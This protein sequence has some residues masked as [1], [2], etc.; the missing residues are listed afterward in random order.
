MYGDGRALLESAVWKCKRSFPH[1]KRIIF[2]RSLNPSLFFP[3]TQLL[4][5]ST[6]PRTKE[7]GRELGIIKSNF[8]RDIADLKRAVSGDVAKRHRHHVNSHTS[9]QLSSESIKSP[10]KWNEKMAEISSDD[11]FIMIIDDGR[12]S[13]DEKTSKGRRLM[14]RQEIN[15]ASSQYS[16]SSDANESIRAM[17]QGERFN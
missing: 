12:E 17:P 5:N 1:L 4:M 9:S 15:E 2:I 13:K 11:K 7:I 16:A 14:M 6:A 10:M 3:T 8:V